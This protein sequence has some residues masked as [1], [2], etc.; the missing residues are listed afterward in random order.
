M[1]AI[2]NFA[3]DWWIGEQAGQGGAPIPQELAHIPFADLWAMMQH[4]FPQLALYHASGF[5]KRVKPLVTIT[6]G[7]E[8]AAALKADFQAS[9]CAPFLKKWWC[10]N[11]DPLEHSS[12]L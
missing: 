9:N 7:K 12:L 8:T 10:F 11:E 2:L 3:V 6:L 4:L 5:M 1:N